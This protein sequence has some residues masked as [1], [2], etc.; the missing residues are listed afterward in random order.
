[1]ASVDPIVNDNWDFT[2]HGYQR[3][4]AMHD[5]TSQKMANY[6][7][8]YAASL[9]YVIIKSNAWFSGKDSRLLGF[10]HHYSGKLAVQ[11]LKRMREELPTKL[12]EDWI[13]KVYVS[14]QHLWSNEGVSSL[15][16]CH[17]LSDS[18]YCDRGS[19]TVSSNANVFLVLNFR[20][21]AKEV[22]R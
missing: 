18:V 8:A 11:S 19:P 12:T 2:E 7:R 6:I 20:R 5:P 16:L 17:C 3:I 22:R 1:M 4:A 9:G 21:A 15:H 14:W 10:A 13:A